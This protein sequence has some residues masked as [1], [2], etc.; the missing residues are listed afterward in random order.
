MSFESQVN[1]LLAMCP[2]YENESKLTFTTY[3]DKILSKFDWQST[4]ATQFFRYYRKYIDPICELLIDN[5]LPNLNHRPA[6]FEIIDILNGWIDGTNDIDVEPYLETYYAIVCKMLKELNRNAL[7]A[8][9]MG[10]H[11]GSDN[12]LKRFAGDS[13]YI[14]DVDSVIRDFLF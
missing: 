6:L 1:E 13:L 14:Y 12:V 8:F 9:K 3:H 5:P 7:C 10:M 4:S 11:C 2:Y